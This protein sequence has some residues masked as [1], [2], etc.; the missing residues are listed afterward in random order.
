LSKL[1]RKGGEALGG[2]GP[3]HSKKASV[4][5]G[6]E[7]N[8]RERRELS[9]GRE[10]TGERGFKSASRR[11]NSKKEVSGRLGGKSRR[12]AVKQNQGT[13]LNRSAKN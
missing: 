6:K 8:G 2:G 11:K 1:M 3:K 7:Y 12:K 13:E 5:L 4:A 9:K 10:A